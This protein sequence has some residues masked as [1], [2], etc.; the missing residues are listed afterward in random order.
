MAFALC[1]QF[2]NAQIINDA[3]VYMY[4]DFESLQ[5]VT[6]DIV[7]TK[8][9]LEFNNNTGSLTG[10][11]DLVAN[12]FL[13]FDA[14]NYGRFVSASYISQSNSVHT[15][16]KSHSMA[17][18]V[19]S[20]TLLNQ[21][22]FILDIANNGGAAL[23]GQVPMRFR[24][25]NSLS[26]SESNGLNDTNTKTTINTWYHFA[27]VMDVA[28]GTQKLYINGFLDKTDA[29]ISPRNVTNNI[30]VGSHKDGT[31]SKFQGHMDD[32]VI[33]SEVWTQDQVRAIMNLGVNAAK[34]TTTKVWT[35]GTT[36]WNTGSNWSP[37]G[38]PTASNDVV[39]PNLGNDP[40][41]AGA[42]NVRNMVI[43]KNASLTVAGAVTATSTRVYDGASFI[44]NGDVSAAGDLTYN[45][46]TED[47]TGVPLEWHLLSSPVVGETYNN[48]WIAD[49]F[50]GTGAIDNRAIALFD[51][52]TDADGDWIYHQKDATTTFEQGIGFSTRKTSVN[53]AGDQEQY[54]FIGTYPD[55]DVTLSITDPANDWNL[56]GNPYPAHIQVSAL[57]S[58]F[59]IASIPDAFETVYVWNPTTEMYTGIA[60]S[61]YIAP[62]QGFFVI[63]ENSSANNFV[64]EK[65]MRSHPSSVATFYKNA[66]PKVTLSL[67]N[68]TSTRNTILNYS[69][70]S[71]LSLD[72]GNDIG[73]FGAF[74]SSFS[75]YTHLVSN[76]TGIAFERQALPSTNIETIVVPVGV[77]A[78]AGEE[79]TFSANAENL[80][81]DVNV[82]LEDR[83]TNAYTL[84][85]DS[86]NYKL[87][88]DTKQNGVGRFYLHTSAS[89][90][91]S[92]DSS[93]L[94][95]VSIYKT[96]NSNIRIAGLQEGKTSFQLFNILGKQVVKSSFNANGTKDISLPSLASG[97]YIVKLQTEVGNIS[98]KIILE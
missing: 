28:A 56:I 12:T 91:L 69:D 7:D 52:T 62:G 60:T 3:D 10:D 96:S 25:N 89:K 74:K 57:M 98:K 30:I 90:S 71:T 5:A 37:V 45:V 36:D 38:V 6:N 65:S 46:V 24:N 87:T 13:N 35:G 70:N 93:L 17:V 64:I 40:I 22:R 66:D 21:E 9:N 49:N 79:I 97:V 82:Y 59:N 47:P 1:I 67:S 19:R 20:T 95:T 15:S 72:P 73:L 75:L 76:D 48:I 78:N 42:I 92:I 61:D 43:Q 50:I 8:G 94:E 41:A 63:S 34:S 26:S 68:G 16:S 84:L 31:N 18:W 55:A 81:A 39:I 11:V 83:L 54:S 29:V 85:D 51:N 88:L 23:D 27:V 2:V 53:S 58:A 14:G 32:L 86:S 80:P 77:T 44:A 33:S 4:V